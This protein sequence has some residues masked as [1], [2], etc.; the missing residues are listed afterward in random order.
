MPFR[1]LFLRTRSSLTPTTPLRYSLFLDLHLLK[2][3]Q[4]A[5][6]LMWYTLSPIAMTPGSLPSLIVNPY[7]TPSLLLGVQ[8][9]HCCTPSSRMVCLLYTNVRQSL[10]IPIACKAANPPPYLGCRYSSLSTQDIIGITRFSIVFHWSFLLS[11]SSF[12][13]VSPSKS[14]SFYTAKVY[15]CGGNE[16]V[17][18]SSLCPEK[19]NDVVCACPNIFFVQ[20]FSNSTLPYLDKP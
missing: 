7:D 3:T 20:N 15:G 18:A 16:R 11:A 2:R 9:L 10:D 12:I 1:G 19:N 17:P 14:L 4:A 6:Q 13:G 5:E 8:R